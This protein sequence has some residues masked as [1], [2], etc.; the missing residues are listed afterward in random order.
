MIWSTYPIA[1]AHLIGLTL[2]R[3]TGIPWMADFRDPM[4][5]PDYP[6]AQWHNLLI[7]TI[8]SLILYN[9]RLQKWCL[10]TDR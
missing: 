1:T 4:V 7:R 9:R 2:Q 10:L 8:V 3:L 5:Q 6:V